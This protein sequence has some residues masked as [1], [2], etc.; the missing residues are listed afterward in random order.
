MLNSPCATVF[1]NKAIASKIACLVPGWVPGWVSGSVP[2]W[3]SGSLTQEITETQHQAMKHCDT[4]IRLETMQ[5][6]YQ[7]LVDN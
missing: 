6:C 7:V 3:V 4:K 5:A 2:G 1:I